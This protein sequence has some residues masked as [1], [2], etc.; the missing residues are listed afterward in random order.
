MRRAAAAL[1]LAAA[2]LSGCGGSLP[3]HPPATAAAAPVTASGGSGTTAGAPRVVR[4]VATGLQTPWGLGFLPDGRAVVTERDTHRV[5]LLDAAEGAPRTIGRLDAAGRGGEGGLLGVA[6]SPRFDDDHLLYFYV[7]T[8]DDNRVVRATFDGGLLAEPEVVLDGIP[9]GPIHDGGRLAFGPDGDLYVS[10]GE[11]GDGSLS[12]DRGSL[13]G[14]ILRMTPD[15]DPAPGNPDPGSAVYTW[16]H[17]NVEGLAWDA[18]GRL[19]AS[20]FGASAWDELNLITPGH[21]YGWPA[22]EGDGTDDR[23]VDPQVVWRTDEASPSGLAYADGHLWLG[24]LAGSRLWRVTVHD[25]RASDPQDFFVGDY[26]RL[27]TVVTAP[28]GR[29]WVT[30]SN[31]DGRG[32]PRQGDDRILVVQPSA[33]TTSARRDARRSVVSTAGP[34]SAMAT[35]LVTARRVSQPPVEV[36]SV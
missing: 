27:R 6:V 21:D 30:T 12:H 8:T 3:P 4:T 2:S 26:G 18:D 31:R 23:Y 5:L 36:S 28:D 20:E 32:D 9:A 22:V 34:R 25:G 15:G 14:K 35:A 17:R 7:T 29:L 11:T 24:A 10:T 19:W 33:G 13:A 16:G 1:A